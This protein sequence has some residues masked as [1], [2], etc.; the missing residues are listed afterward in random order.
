[1]RNVRDYGAVGDG[2]TSDTKA[3]Q[4]AIDAGGKVVFPSGTYKT[5]TLFLRSHGGLYL[6]PGAVLLSG[7]EEETWNEPHFCPQ[8]RV[9]VNE[10]T[11]G[12]HL[13]IAY[14]VEDVTI[15]GGCIDGCFSHWFDELN[16]HNP[17]FKLKLRNSQMIFFCN[18]KKLRVRD[19]ELRNSPYWHC[20]FH[21]CEN[22][23]VSGLRIQGHPG[24]PCNDGIDIDCCKFVNIS[25]CIIETGDDA[26]TLRANSQGLH[27]DSHP[28]E[29][30]TV[31]NCI[32]SSRFG[33]GVRLGVGNDVI[34]NCILSDLIIHHS[35]IGVELASS[36]SG[37]AGVTMENLSFRNLML[38]VYRPFK[39]LLEAE[40]CH[41]PIYTHFRDISFTDIHGRAEASTEVFGNK[42]GEI[43]GLHFK[44]VLLDYYGKG[45][46]P[47]V[48]E[49]G[50]WC[51]E[52]TASAFTIRDVKD[53]SFDNLSINWCANED[54]WLHEVE[55]ENSNVIFR[56]CALKKGFLEK[57]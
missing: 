20:F 31:S 56:D 5:G 8:N 17:L 47:F 34:R 15:E 22:I 14:Q 42:T 41:N 26:L 3:I 29:Y 21:G 9:S 39:I 40:N 12:R 36:Y 25:D 1:M 2:V 24:V 18:S 16:S 43:S 19:C 7:G 51:K 32:L 4:S 46:A 27:E 23:S 30:V 10:K 50:Y 55:A 53:I 44:D 33:D 13:I 54:L 45:P 6:E 37:E 11:N 35:N 48:D 57:R 38:E 49:Q 52:S 28:C